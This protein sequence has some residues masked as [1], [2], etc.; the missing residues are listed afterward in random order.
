[1][2]S[3]LHMAMFRVVAKEKTTALATAGPMKDVSMI[4]PSDIS[5]FLR[6][7]VE[8]CDISKSLEGKEKV[9]SKT[10]TNPMEA[11]IICAILATMAS[12]VG[13]HSIG[14]ITPY[15]GQKRLLGVGGK[16]FEPLHGRKYNQRAEESNRNQY[17]RRFSR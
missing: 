17:G 15:D 6:T 2:L 7:I 9:N 11:K 14:V 4:S 13:D 5:I 3:A 1:M 10:L 16:C 8:F 12:A